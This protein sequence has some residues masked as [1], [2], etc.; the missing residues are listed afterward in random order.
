MWGW[1]NENKFWF[2]RGREVKRDSD[3]NCWCFV[4]AVGVGRE[5][6][7]CRMKVFGDL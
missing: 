1:G 2:Y 7:F 6:V 5:R 3:F 4:L